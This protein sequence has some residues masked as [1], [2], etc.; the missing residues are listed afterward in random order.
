VLAIVGSV[1]DYI[2]SLVHNHYGVVCLHGAEQRVMHCNYESEGVYQITNK[3][4][5]TAETGHGS[6]HEGDPE[7]RSLKVL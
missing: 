7:S 2:N 6:G 3:F 1:I 4:D 5:V